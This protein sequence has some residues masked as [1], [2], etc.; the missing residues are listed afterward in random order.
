M[1]VL[2]EQVTH[3]EELVGAASSKSIVS[4]SNRINV[5]ANN[6][7]TLAHNLELFMV[8]T[9]DKFVNVMEDLMTFNDNLKVR[10]EALET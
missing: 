7:D 3:L 1:E 4:L 8:D 5:A 6:L 10:M 2:C 9:N